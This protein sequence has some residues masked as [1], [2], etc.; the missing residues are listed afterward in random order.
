M[1]LL[2]MATNPRYPHLCVITRQTLGGT[3]AAPTKTTST[4]L[5]S[6]CR[7]YPD[8][9]GSEKGG[10]KVADYKVSLESLSVA[11]KKG[12]KI[13]CTDSLMTVVGEIKLWHVGNLGVNIWFNVNEN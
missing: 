6:A 13:T 9:S 3:N 8:N 5:S 2:I 4:V 7:F 10:V 1:A 11:L 12:D